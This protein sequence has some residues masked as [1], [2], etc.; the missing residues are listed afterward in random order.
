[1]AGAWFSTSALLAKLPKFNTR[2]VDPSDALRIIY[3]ALIAL[4]TSERA[5]TLPKPSF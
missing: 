2:G 1:V 4:L 5:T 3:F